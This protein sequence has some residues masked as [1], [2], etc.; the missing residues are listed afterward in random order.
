M[1]EQAWRTDGVI[2]AGD[3]RSAWEE[4]CPSATVSIT[5]FTCTGLGLNLGYNQPPE[6]QH[7]CNAEWFCFVIYVTGLDRPRNGDDDDNGS[8]ELIM[9][10]FLRDSAVYWMTVLTAYWPVIWARN[11]NFFFNPHR[12]CTHLSEVAIRCHNDCHCHF[13]FGDGSSFIRT[14][15]IDTT[16]NT[17]NYHN[18][19]VICT[20]L[21][22]DSLS[23]LLPHPTRLYLYLPGL[24]SRCTLLWLQVSMLVMLI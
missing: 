20:I 14:N 12:S 6:L 19:E 13:I 16:W 15:N 5:S 3:N 21:Y 8:Y 9:L 10:V 23:I 11:F 17:T 1:T 22:S 4:A 2:L 18:S 24:N 7:G